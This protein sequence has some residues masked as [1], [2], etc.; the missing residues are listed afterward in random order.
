MKIGLQDIKILLVEDE[1]SL[2]QTI[3]KQLQDVGYLVEHSGNGI[4]AQAKISQKE[5]HLIILD[6]MLPE[7]SG[8]DVLQELRSKQFTTP[9]LILT[10]LDGSKNRVKGLNLGA[11]DYLLKPFDSGELIARIEAILRR[12]G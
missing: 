12:S 2:A 7:K 4:D 11:D 5:F 10:G 8:F 9:V 3:K 6:L 1:K